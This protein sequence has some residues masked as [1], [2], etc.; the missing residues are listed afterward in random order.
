MNTISISE[1]HT[2]NEGLNLLNSIMVKL[3]QKSW[4][5]FEWNQKAILELKDTDHYFVGTNLSK[6]VKD[7]E[8]IT[9]DVLS[10]TGEFSFSEQNLS[11][12]EKI[13]DAMER[14]LYAF[15]A[16][17][18]ELS[19]KLNSDPDNI[20]QLKEAISAIKQITDTLSNKAELL[21]AATTDLTIPGSFEAVVVFY[22]ATHLISSSDFR[23]LYK[24]LQ[25][26]SA[27]YCDALEVDAEKNFIVDPY[28]DKIFFAL[29]SI[30]FALKKFV[31]GD[32]SFFFSC[33]AASSTID[34]LK[35]AQRF[36]EL[37]QV[38]AEAIKILYV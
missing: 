1:L 34:F 9:D 27:I 22:A 21:N 8:N 17:F 5:F 4:F 28:K 26:I 35:T 33:G 29:A 13:L 15:I 18:S 38:S 32:G 24:H 36:P 20:Q 12:L 10:R 23:N 14:P 6:W 31:N 16:E 37:L 30:L 11:S 3:L 25:D 2:L 7:L 19:A